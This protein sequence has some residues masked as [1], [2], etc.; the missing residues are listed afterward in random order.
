MSEADKMF[1]KLGYKKDLH[2]DRKGKVWGEMFEE[3]RYCKRVSFDY[4]DKEICV[5]T[6]YVCD[7]TLEHEP[8]YFNMQDL[9]AINE[10][11]KELGWND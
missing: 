7:K 9:Q 5:C 10:K 4:I 11:V 6:N 3:D 2:T 1:E 8:I